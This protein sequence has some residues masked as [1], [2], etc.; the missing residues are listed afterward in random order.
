MRQQ[1][2]FGRE[3]P[4]RH[5][6]G[7]IPTESSRMPWPRGAPA[8]PSQALGS[9]GAN[10]DGMVWGVRAVDLAAG[11]WTPT[12]PVEPAPGQTLLRRDPGLRATSA[13]AA[14]D[15]VSRH[16]VEDLRFAPS[17]ADLPLW[18]PRSVCAAGGRLR[19]LVSGGVD[20]AVG[21][22]PAAR[23][24]DQRVGW[25]GRRPGGRLGATGRR[26]LEAVREEPTWRRRFAL[27]DEFLLGAAE[28]G[29]RPSPEVARA[30]QLIRDSSGA[31]GIGRVA[32]EVGWSHKHLIA[33]FVPAGRVDAQDGG[34]AGA[35]RARCRPC[36]VWSRGAPSPESHLPTMSTEPV[37]NGSR[38]AGTPGGEI[39]P[40]PQCTTRIQHLASSAGHRG[41]RRVRSR[42]WLQLLRMGTGEP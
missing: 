18:S 31:V 26:L 15:R 21:R 8:Q 23:Q 34:A 24:A 5:G 22:V 38:K 4:A 3:A 25:R 12:S 41:H 27:L 39:R 33:K 36:Q 16:C 13:A 17:S 1:D 20:G 35:L 9:S 30:W 29:P 37:A 28:K 2:P 14:G 42:V 40:R 19:P 10:A 11:G 32:D 6:G 7:V